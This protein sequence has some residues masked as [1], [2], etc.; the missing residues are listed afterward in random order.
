MD[1]SIEARIVAALQEVRPYLQIDKGDVE[2]V[3]Y[4]PDTG[5][6]VLRFSGACVGCA[7]L[8]ITLRAGVERTIRAA[9]EEVKR[10]EI[11]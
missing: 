5:V 1:T 7:M 8:P 11:G 9:V 6:A 10:V 2:L 4:E 3:R